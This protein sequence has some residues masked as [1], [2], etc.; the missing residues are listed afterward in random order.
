M[1][2]LPLPGALWLFAIVVVA[3]AA[4]TTTM[5]FVITI[6]PQIHHR[7]NRN[8]A[9]TTTILL[10][11]VNL[12]DLEGKALAAAEAWDTYVTPFYSPEEASQVEDSLGNRADVTCLRIDGGGSP[13]SNAPAATTMSRCRFLFTN[14]DLGMDKITAEAEYGTVLRVENAYLESMD[15]WPNVLSTIGVDLTKVGDI[16]VVRNTKTAYL[17]V[18]PEIAKVCSR[19]LPKELPGAGVTVSAL[20]PGDDVAFPPDDSELQDMDLK[21]LDKRAQKRK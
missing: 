9:T 11:V 19:L 18:D 13:N 1:Q 10:G 20:E 16:V 15:P 4:S 6:R 12:K 3:Q 8:C 5:A 7:H 14:P 2:L 21:R 17:V